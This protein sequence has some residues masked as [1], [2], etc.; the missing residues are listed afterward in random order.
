MKTML[1]LLAVV[2]IFPTGCDSLQGAIRPVQTNGGYYRFPTRTYD[3]QADPKAMT[4]LEGDPNSDFSAETFYPD[5]TPKAKVTR[6]RSVVL[7]T[8][9]GGVK[10]VEEA[11]AAIAMQFAQ[12]A[13]EEIRSLVPIIREMQAESRAGRGGVSSTDANLRSQIVSA[14]QQAVAAEIQRRL[15]ASSQPGMVTLP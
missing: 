12:M 10:T 14:V 13:L 9:F 1:G 4:V 15:P 5:G 3:D 6:K 7:D 11:R 8:I 2:L